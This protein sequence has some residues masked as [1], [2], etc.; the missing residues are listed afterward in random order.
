MKQRAQMTLTVQLHTYNKSIVPLECI[1][2]E[3]H[4]KWLEQ[5]IKRKENITRSLLQLKVKTSKLPKARENASHQIVFFISFECDWSRKW[6]EFSE[7]ITQHSEPTPQKSRITLETQPI[8]NY[9]CVP[10]GQLM[11]THFGKVYHGFRLVRQS[12]LS[13]QLDTATVLRYKQRRRR[14]LYYVKGGGGGKSAEEYVG[15]GVQQT[16]GAPYP[17]S[18]NGLYKYN[19]GLTSPPWDKK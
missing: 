19:Q 10:I 6:R 9:S 7:P 2:I 4:T 8:K 3:C 14:R 17:S 15:G 5:P 18:Y 16:G 13:Y 12:L 1:S 11:T